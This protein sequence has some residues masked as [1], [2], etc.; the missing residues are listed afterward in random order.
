[1]YNYNYRIAD[2]GI[3]ISS[4]FPL[5]TGRL[6]IF[7]DETPESTGKNGLRFVIAVGEICEGK[8]SGKIIR[9]ERNGKPAVLRA[10]IDDAVVITVE[11]DYI[12]AFGYGLLMEALEL[13]MEFML[14]GAVI[15]HSAYIVCNQSAILFTAPPEGG[16]TTQAML[17]EKYLGAEI[18]NGD[19]A[20]L[21]VE[22]LKAEMLNFE[23]GKV[24]AFGNP[25]C[26]MSE[27]CRNAVFPL[28]AVVIV[29]KAKDNDVI[30]IRRCGAAEAVAA[31]CGGIPGEY[32]DPDTVLFIAEHIPF[33]RLKCRMDHESARLAFDEIFS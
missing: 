25:Y 19:R 26:G 29:E 9:D 20:M 21:K 14:R 16:K 10:K 27:I 1:M 5:K 11:N 31:L 13:P 15:F 22:T 2:C 7:C 18:I 3:E 6:E 32:T 24:L 4:D 8:T 17:W 23:G 33:Y 12:N 28:K 30:S